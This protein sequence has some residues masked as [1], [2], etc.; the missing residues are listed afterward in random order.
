MAFNDINGH[1]NADRVRADPT[2]GFYVYFRE[3]IVFNPMIRMSLR[4]PERMLL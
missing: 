3:L 2:V 1:G 4:L